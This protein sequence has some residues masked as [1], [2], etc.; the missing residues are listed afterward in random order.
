MAEE[1]PA[2]QAPSAVESEES[3]L[4][5]TLL[6]K[7]LTSKAAEDKKAAAG[8][9]A[10]LLTDHGAGALKAYG[11]LER[12]T[13]AMEDKKSAVA[14]EGALQAVLSLLEGE[15]KRDCEAYVV[16]ILPKLMERLGDKAKP[17]QTLAKSAVTKLFEIISPHATKIVVPVLLENMEYTKSWQQKSLALELLELLSKNARRQLAACLPEIVP[18]VSECFHDTKEQVTTA[19]VVAMKAVT[20][21]VGNKDIDPFV[22]AVISCIAR[23]A[24]VPECVHK[25]SATTFVQTVEAP[26]LSIMVPLLARGMN[27]RAVAIKRKTAV[28]IDNMSKLVDNPADAAP[29]L[30]KLLPGLEK[31][32]K[33]VSDPEC[34][35]VAAKA[36]ATLVRVGGEGKF[37]APKPVNEAVVLS[38]LKEV[39]KSSTKEEVDQSQI[40][41]LEYVTSLC[42]TLIAAKSFEI[43]TWRDEVI[44]P[45]LA[46]VI[47]KGDF[48]VVSSAFLALCVEEAREKVVEVDEDPA[49]DLCNCEFSLAYGGKIL[50]NNARLHLKRGR[51]Y[52]LCGANGSGK[53]TL[54]RAIANGQLEG[55]P[56]K[57]ELR[58]VYV[59]HDIDASE[60]DTPVLEFILHDSALQDATHPAH[61]HVESVLASVGFT[62]EM[63][64][65][66]VA[67]LSGGWKMKLA[68]ARAMLMK[69]DIM[70]L[71]EPTNH[72]DV[73]NVAWLENYL[74]NLPDVTSMLVS[75]DSGFLDNVCTD[76]IHYENL[77]L[78]HYRGNLSEF[79][80]VKPEAR[81]YYELGAAEMK[82]KF[83]EPGFLEGVKSKD[84]AILK[85]YNNSFTYPGTTK[86]VLSGITIMCSL[87][88]RVAVVG[89]NGAGKSTMIKL[90]TGEMEPNSG[91]V[92]KHPNLRMAYVAQHAFHHLE[93]HLDMT[94]NQYIQWRYASG[95]DREEVGK[96]SRK[97]TEEEE[98]KMQ[99]QQV[100]DGKKKVVEKLLGRRKLKK[101]YEYEV[102][103]VGLHSDDNSWLTRDKLEEMGFAKMV[104][105]IDAKE[106]AKSGL[107]TRPLT[108]ANIEKHLLDFGIEPEFGTHNRV[109]GLSGGQKV[110]VVLAAAMWNQPHML[111]LDEPTNYLDRDSLGALANAIK[112][113]G[114]GVV[115]ITHNSEFSSALC[116][117]TWIVANGTLTPKGQPAAVVAAQ[118]LEWKR[119]EE[120]LDQFGNTVKIAEKKKAL[121]AKEKKKRERIRAMK[122]KNGEPVSD[123]EEED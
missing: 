52:G 82:F 58:T 59:E 31:M 20:S 47:K 2:A 53:S 5:G 28:I 63:L 121:S 32:S 72:L 119:E 99:A 103:W 8:E 16:P 116:P 55:F 117:E 26:T 25:L 17:V 44:A 19:A 71:D 66:P 105:E 34:R 23:P 24:E 40:R 81:S 118:K 10:A 80:K 75:H 43:G 85:M 35:Q 108:V 13:A 42:A 21:V 9:L 46:P 114:G 4:V 97:V 36:H 14:R 123:S 33:E 56:P 91:T 41:T 61:G 76:I 83:P 102:Q 45:Y 67:S 84:R 62:E 39:I 77:K 6:E 93:Q 86:E 107:F 90:L 96:V 57:E 11:A 49:P 122:K 113:Y 30:P 38:T 22:P 27:E 7:I 111:I 92:W 70:L 50:L 110:K 112:E 64:K 94:A 60:A 120:T 109:R 18:V 37:T 95:E 115:M 3:K 12:L 98:K 73:T 29:F 78:K 100:H 79:V 15:S 1:A 69:A 48:E 101:S 106:A 65:A 87:N 68:L 89:A 54:M 74:T 104:N 51:R 88:S